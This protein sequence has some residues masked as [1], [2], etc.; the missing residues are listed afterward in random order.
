MKDRREE[1]LKIYQVGLLAQANFSA[2]T[3][4]PAHKA[5]AG[6]RAALSV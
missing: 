2:Q 3:F 5:R 4:N 6:E 1:N